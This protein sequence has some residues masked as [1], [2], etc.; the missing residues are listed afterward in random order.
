MLAVPAEFV[1]RLVSE[2]STAAMAHLPSIGRRVGQ[3]PYGSRLADDGQHLEAEPVEAA[4]VGV[5]RELRASGLIW[6]A[7]ADEL[8]CR[9]YT[10]KKGLAWTWRTAQA[11][12]RAL[13]N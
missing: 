13:W 7:V 10:T 2:R 4:I 12:A 8:N 3:V 5:L 9:G 11:A 1:R 6:Q